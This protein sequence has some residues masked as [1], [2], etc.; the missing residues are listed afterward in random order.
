[1]ILWG[2]TTCPY[3][4]SKTIRSNIT[5]YRN[6]SFSDSTPTCHCHLYHPRFIDSHHKHI[7]T[8]DLSIIKNVALRNLLS[9]GLNF[10]DMTVPDKRK[11]FQMFQSA[12][13]IYISKIS[14]KLTLPSSCFTGWKSQILKII[15]SDLDKLTPMSY[16]KVLGHAKVKEELST[17]KDHFILSPI[18]K[19]SCNVSLICK[20]YYRDLLYSE[21]TTSGNVTPVNNNETNIIN[22]NTNYTKNNF[23]PIPTKHESLPYLYLTPKNHKSPIGTRFITCSTNTTHSNLSKSVGI[24]LKTILKTEKNHSTYTNK[25]KKYKNYFI[26]DNRDEVIKYMQEHNNSD[27]PYKKSIKSYDFSNLYT[28]IPHNKLLS[29][30]SK[31]IHKVF[32]LKNKKFITIS[33]NHAYFANTATISLTADALIEHIDFIVNN[34]FIVFQGKVYRQIIGIPM[35]TNCAPYLAN[36]FLHVYECEFID[37]CIENG[38]IDVAENIIGMFRYQD[39]C[40]VFD[41]FGA[42]ER[43]IE[44][45]Y[46]S[47]MS[48]K[49]T[50]TSAA[51]CSYL[52]LTISV[53]KGQ[54]NYRSYDK[55]R[56][57]N[58]DVVNYPNLTGNIPNGPSYGIFTSQLV[59]FCLIN[60]TFDYFVKDANNLVKKLLDQ[61][62]N[63]GILKSKFREFANTKLNVWAKFGV[64]IKLSCNMSRIFKLKS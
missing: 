26:I 55:R 42:F 46:P 61:S 63:L 49:C 29:C 5:N 27:K 30:T 57:F 41:D 13:D 10:R 7:I 60:K 3:K 48:L 15:K 4:Y 21:L 64:D 47:E 22:E 45:I 18:D 40:V 52:D 44:D 11:A 43:H 12:L 56:D 37:K 25:F 50:N 32:N 59:R 19:A 1:M 51:K 38:D 14:N 34:S 35:G 33:N 28:S 23:K 53:Y 17:L 39:D 58:F 6:I 62:F 54:F 36:I 24:A 9:K 2:L 31:P 16:N 8:G 20:A